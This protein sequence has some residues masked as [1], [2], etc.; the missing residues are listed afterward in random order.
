MAKH[1]INIINPFLDKKGGLMPALHAVQDHLGFISK[2][3][4][5]ELAIAFNCS[6]AEVIDVITFYDDFRLKAI[7]K[8]IIKICQAEA[9][10][11][12]NCKELL[13][14][15]TSHFG[16]NINET[17][18]DLN[19]TLKEVFCL[20]NCAIGPSVM[21]NDMVI[22]EATTEKVVNQLKVINA[23]E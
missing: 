20:G 9:C 18:N 1:L 3:N 19:I 21:I 15:L 11:S 7:G 8:N 12:Q 23:E 4:I 13:H 10:Q 14:N 6:Q 2:D 22:G 17:S 16:L 5:R